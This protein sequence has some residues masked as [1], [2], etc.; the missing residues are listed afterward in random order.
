M[1]IKYNPLPALKDL[2]I[3]FKYDPLSGE[4]KNLRLGHV[5]KTVDTKGY[6]AV[7]FHGKDYRVHRICYFLGTGIDPS[8]LQVDHKDR[9]R[10]N[11]KLDNL[12]LLN[13]S[14][15]QMNTKN[16]K[17]N[18]SGRKGVFFDKK[19]MKWR[20]YITIDREKLWLYRGESWDEAVKQREK[21]EEKYYPEVFKMTNA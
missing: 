20:S 15:Q 4:L 13:N 3:N 10:I 7:H 5:V 6:L 12:R 11:N 19:G 21:A 16:R 18:K 1:T 9:N 8:N 2:Q 14:Q 17:D